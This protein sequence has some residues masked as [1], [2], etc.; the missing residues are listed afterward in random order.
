MCDH[1]LD[2]LVFQE[3]SLKARV[4]PILNLIARPVWKHL[5]NLAP[6]GA[7][8]EEECHDDD[9]F[10]VREGLLRSWFQ[11]KGVPVTTLLIGAPYEVVSNPGPLLS[12]HL[13]NTENEQ[14]VLILG[15][16]GVGLCRVIIIN[17]W[18]IVCMVQRVIGVEWMIYCQVDIEGW[19]YILSVCLFSFAKVS[20]L[21]YLL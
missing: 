15:P 6:A 1:Q 11:L 7:V 21:N 20:L 8:L 17:G 3:S 2:E 5:G 14:L 4:I 16:G 19:L 12:T 13:L 9:V 10:L 18:Y